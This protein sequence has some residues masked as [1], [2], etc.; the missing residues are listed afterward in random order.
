VKSNYTIKL[1]VFSAFLFAISYVLNQ[2]LTFKFKNEQ[3]V[4]IVVYLFVLT[5][6]MHLAL[7]KTFT[8]RPQAFVYRYMGFSGLRLVLH[9]FLLIAYWLV[10][11]DLLVS[12]TVYFLVLYLLFTIFEI[13][14]LYRDIKH[15]P[16]SK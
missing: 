2:S 14:F 5:L 1:I 6:L 4:F 11:K 9:F 8:E 12:F 16:K 3:A 10:F 15:L 7:R 13:Y